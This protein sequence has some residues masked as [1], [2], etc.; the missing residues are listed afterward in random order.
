M[1]KGKEFQDRGSHDKPVITGIVETKLN[2][3]IRSHRV[4]YD[5][6]TVTRKERAGRGREMEPC[7]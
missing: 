2:M 7:W 1:E 6:Y 5:R 4:F 3:D